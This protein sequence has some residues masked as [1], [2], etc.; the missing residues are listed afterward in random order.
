MLDLSASEV[1]SPGEAEHSIQQRERTER[2]DQN[3]I[4]VPITGVGWWG[5]ANPTTKS[6][7]VE[8]G[9]VQERPGSRGGSVEA[10]AER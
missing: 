9:E 7:R 3:R 8:E 2:S 6:A 4:Q 10:D 5:E 1:C